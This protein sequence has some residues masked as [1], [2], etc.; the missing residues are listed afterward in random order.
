VRAGSIQ[1]ETLIGSLVLAGGVFVGAGLAGYTLLGAGLGMGLVLGSLN[2]F[3]I[4]LTL[5][6]GVPMLASGLLRMAMLTLLALIAA[7]LVGTTVWPVV[8][9][10][11]GA[12]LVMVGIGV[13]QG[14]RA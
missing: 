6:R 9:G 13:R 4:K 1:Q 14:W 10:I 8:A 7:R 5:D 3:I 2:A 11:A 12:Q